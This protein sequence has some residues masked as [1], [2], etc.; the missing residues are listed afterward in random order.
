MR[1]LFSNKK[2]S[3]YLYHALNLALERIT[4]DKFKWQ[5]ICDEA[6]ENI[7]QFEECKQ[8]LHNTTPKIWVSS[9]SIARWF[10]EY[11]SNNDYF[12]NH[13]LRLS[14]INR[15]PPIFNY[16]PN[17][18]MKFITFGKCNLVVPLTA[19]L[20]HHYMMSELVPEVR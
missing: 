10:R 19:E 11:R 9:Y 15:L 17:I 1:I 5:N 7:N 13:P 2:K 8:E 6:A 3:K 14:R 12:T 16:H 20:M 18:M 4:D